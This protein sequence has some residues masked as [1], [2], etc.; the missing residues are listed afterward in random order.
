MSTPFKINEHIFFPELL[1]IQKTAEKI[2][3]DPKTSALLSYLIK[4]AG[5]II[6]RDQLL[7]N[8]WPNVIVNDNSV[9][10]TISQLRKALGDDA[11]APTFIRTIPKKGYQFIASVNEVS[12]YKPS[13][14]T[15]STTKKL[16]F[17]KSPLFITVVFSLFALFAIFNFFYNSTNPPEFK[18]G[19]A[20]NIT[21]LEG[22]EESPSLSPDELL[23]LF[24]Y[25][26][27]Q[28]NNKFQLYLKPLKEN[29]LFRETLADG[30]TTSKKIAS[31]RDV[32]PFALT[33]DEYEYHD[34][35]WGKDN[36]E[37]YAVRTGD[38]KEG[39]VRSCEVVRL[40]MPIARDKIIDSTLITS[41]HALAYTKL[42]YKQNS[43]VLYFTDRRDT[44]QYA[45]YKHTLS[46]SKE[47]KLTFP[48]TQGQGDHF[49]DINQQQDTLLILRDSYW[50]NTDFI[51]FDLLSEKEQLLSTVESYYYSAF[52]GKDGQ[53]IW[54]NWGNEKVIAYTPTTQQA[55]TILTTSFGWNYNAKPLNSHTIIFN[56]GNDNDGDLA[57]WQ[58]EKVTIPE[59]ANTQILPAVTLNGNKIAF[60]SNQT[61]I[62]QI[63]IKDTQNNIPIQVT[64]L[65]KYQE[66][67]SLTWAKDNHQLLGISQETIGILNTKL[68]TFNLVTKESTRAFYPSWSIDNNKV[69]FTQKSNNAWRIFSVDIVKSID[70]PKPLELPKP[71]QLINGKFARELNASTLLF[72]MENVSG[73][74]T[75]D[76]EKQM[77]TTLFEHF[78]KNTFWQIANDHIYFISTI[79]QL[80]LYKT[81]LDTFTP[82][83]I[84]PLEKGVGGQF[85]LSKSAD[86]II[87]EDRRRKQSDLKIAPLLP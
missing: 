21:S 86:I 5:E 14:T 61:G 69:Y 53:T 65:N 6:S 9:N 50:A 4:H 77:V 82:Q 56:V 84:T 52:W 30:Q 40:V 38:E 33:D 70:L 49:I 75:F 25:K 32:P 83:L 73:L 46:S 7:D 34:M 39:I 1:E 20:V 22:K 64:N 17:I 67:N 79:S 63:F 76:I 35:V 85:T 43:Q 74:F 62:P 45:L 19:K 81:K 59:T 26:S 18:V 54:H 55:S 71:K 16:K 29:L 60:V 78:P 28:P 48:N 8:V 36:F 2:N 72:S 66:F 87:F 11:N 42:A 10:W 51:A 31:L 37:I 15:V 47:E 57:Y 58:N 3:L 41:C 12:P 27:S 44:S 68:N 13:A 80:G 24:R 23:L